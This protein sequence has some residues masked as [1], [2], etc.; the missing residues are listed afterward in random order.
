MYQ[1]FYA[2][3]PEVPIM[4]ISNILMYITA[5]LTLISGVKYLYDYREF[6]NPNK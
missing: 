1:D 3:I 4:L 5:A 2:P 6:I